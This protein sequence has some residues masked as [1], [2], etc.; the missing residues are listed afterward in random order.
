MVTVPTTAGASM[1]PMNVSF[2]KDVVPIFTNR[3]CVNCHSGNGPGKDLGG[4]QL[5][6]GAAKV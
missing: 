3:G 4:L 5:S 2:A 6:G 1:L